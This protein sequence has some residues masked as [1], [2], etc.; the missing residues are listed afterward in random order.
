MKDL[1]TIESRVRAILSNHQEARD[2]TTFSIDFREVLWY[3]FIHN[4]YVTPTEK[5]QWD[6]WRYTLWRKKWLTFL[7][8]LKK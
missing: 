5:F 3:H 8:C 2:V 4:I 6:L 1:K 7:S